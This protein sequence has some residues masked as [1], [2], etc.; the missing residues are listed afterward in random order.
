[1]RGYSYQPGIETG[2]ALAT[3]ESNESPVE[4]TTAFA[5]ALGEVAA[6]IAAMLVAGVTIEAERRVRTARALRSATATKRA[7]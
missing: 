1:M 2:T 7:A 4:L 5:D 6:A 3:T